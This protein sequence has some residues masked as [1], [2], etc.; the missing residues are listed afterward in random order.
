MRQLAHP[1]ARPRPAFCILALT[2]SLFLVFDRGPVG[3][4]QGDMEVLHQLIASLLHVSPGD[5]LVG[6]L[7]AS[8][9]FD[10]SIT[11]GTRIIGS[12]VRNPRAGAA[13]IAVPGDEAAA[14][15]LLR[16]R[17]QTAGWTA[18][19]P[20]PHRGVP[21]GFQSSAPAGPTMLCSDPHMVALYTPPPEAPDS[22]HVTVNW[23]RHEDGGPGPCDPDAA[24]SRAFRSPLP[25]LAAPADVQVRQEGG[26]RGASGDHSS[27]ALMTDRPIERILEHYAA[28]LTRH[29]MPLGTREVAGFAAVQTF[30]WTD[31]TGADWEGELVLVRSKSAHG[32]VVHATVRMRRATR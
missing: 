5:L 19:P 21:G 20:L 4:Q 29:G 8:A 22:T 11:A 18:R 9:P 10:A 27:A 23:T 3:A 16:Q 30:S 15:A 1:T 32:P 28:E 13:V 17:F 6:E 7:H 25:A 12:I 14:I 31:E 2:A 24:G 26:G